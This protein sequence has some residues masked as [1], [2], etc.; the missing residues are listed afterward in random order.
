MAITREKSRIASRSLFANNA[1]AAF[2]IVT[3]C[4]VYGASAH[5]IF[6]GIQLMFFISSLL[7]AVSVMYVRD[8]EVQKSKVEK[9]ILYTET[10]GVA[11]I[12]IYTIIFGISSIALYTGIKLIFFMTSYVFVLSFLYLRHPKRLETIE[13]V[14]SSLTTNIFHERFPT[15]VNSQDLSWLIRELNDPLASIIG[16]SELMLERKYG[17]HEKEYMLR[18]IYQSAIS[19]SYTVNK[20]AKTITDTPAKPKQIHEVVDLLDDKNFK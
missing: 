4:I 1:I 5:A 10:V 16:F 8:P 2:L 6:D 14:S 3:Y 18:C 7:F 17:E 9:G 12:A 13:E 19:M 11:L 20:V 15:F